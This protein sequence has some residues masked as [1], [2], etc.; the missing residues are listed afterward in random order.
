MFLVKSHL[1][2]IIK[3]SSIFLM[4]LLQC[5][6]SNNF[7]CGYSDDEMESIEVYCTNFEGTVPVN[8][9]TIFFSTIETHNKSQVTSLKLGGCD[10]EQIQQVVADFPNLRSLDVSF[11]G[12]K[13]LSTFELRLD[14]LVGYII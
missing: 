7:E 5:C 10:Q 1:N 8:C 13:N 9:S 12:I 3:I 4:I 2:Q 11:S 6:S 14:F